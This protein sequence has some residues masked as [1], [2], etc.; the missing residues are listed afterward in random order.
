M[1]DDDLVEFL[2]WAL[3]RLERKWSG[4]R[5]VRGQVGGR[6]RDRLVE[7]GLGDLDAYRDYL[8]EHQEEWEVLDR[9][10]RIT[11]SK[12]YRGRATWDLLR[13]DVLPELVRRARRAGRERLRAWSIGCASGEEPYTLRLCWELDV[14]E[15]CAETGLDIVAT[16]ADEHMLERAKAACYPSGCLKELPEEWRQIAFEEAGAEQDPWCLREEF[17]KGVAFAHQDVRREQPKGAFDLVFCRY[18]VL[19][20]FEEQVQRE[21]LGN[22]AARMREGAALVIGP[23]EDLPQG[24]GLEPWN[25]SRKVYRRVPAT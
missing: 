11:I 17:R 7:L 4:Y 16:D 1:R 14:G 3:P 8:R 21:V 23:K 2:Q 24:C 25:A 22:V 10:C 20:Y 6:I 15:R 13:E 12:F 5:K 19:I 18:V 9:F